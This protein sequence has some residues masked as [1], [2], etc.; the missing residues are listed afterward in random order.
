[1]ER[2]DVMCLLTVSQDNTHNKKRIGY[3]VGGCHKWTSAYRVSSR[4]SGDSSVWRNVVVVMGALIM[5]GVV[6]VVAG[7]RCC[8]WRWRWLSRGTPIWWCGSSSPV[9]SSGT[10]SRGNTKSLSGTS[11]PSRLYVMGGK[12]WMQTGWQI[13]LS[14]KFSESDLAICPFV[15]LGFAFSKLE[16]L[17][18]TFSS[19]STGLSSGSVSDV[20]SDTF[21]VKKQRTNTNRRK[22]RANPETTPNAMA[23]ADSLMDAKIGAKGVSILR[24]DELSSRDPVITG[25]K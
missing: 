16:E 19:D 17:N 22:T 8:C 9:N 13:H 1:M 15:F 20:T 7:I 25:G 6:I 11:F 10:D 18:P 23:F 21:R 4:T 3:L 2:R 5:V 24:E 12:S 14:E